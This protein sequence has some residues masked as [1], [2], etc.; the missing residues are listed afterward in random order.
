M[1]AKAARL[2]DITRRTDINGHVVPA[3]PTEAE[4]RTD[5]LRRALAA[6]VDAG[7]QDGAAKFAEALAL[8]N[9]PAPP[10]SA[11]QGARPAPTP[12]PRPAGPMTP[13]E[14]T[15]SVIRKTAQLHRRHE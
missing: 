10:G 12:T 9:T 4:H 11:D 3:V 6:A 15:E 5:V 2:A 7:D 1:A 14:A 8:A 13:T